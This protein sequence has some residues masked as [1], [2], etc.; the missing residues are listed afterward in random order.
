M[1]DETATRWEQRKA[2]ELCLSSCPV[3]DQCHEWARR[4]KFTGTAAGQR[5]LYGRRRGRTD[6]ATRGPDRAS[7]VADPR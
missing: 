5:L 6:A 1:Y 3:I 2:Q 4:E 7:G